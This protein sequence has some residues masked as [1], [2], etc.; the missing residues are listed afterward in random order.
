MR[1][2]IA[3]AILAI[4][5]GLCAGLIAHAG[6]LTL[7]DLIKRFEQSE[8]GRKTMYARQGVGRFAQPRLYKSFRDDS[9]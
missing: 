9:Q 6:G 4:A 8:E 1:T 5:I 7:N 3:V 2:T